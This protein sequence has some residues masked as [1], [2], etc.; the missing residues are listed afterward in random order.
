MIIKNR[1][2][3]QIYFDVNSLNIPI[4]KSFQF[5]T[6]FSLNNFQFLYSV[7]HLCVLLKQIYL[8]TNFDFYKKLWYWGYE[9]VSNIML[10]MELGSRF[11]EMKYEMMEIQ[12]QEMDESR[13]VLVWDRDL[14]VP[15]LHALGNWSCSF[16]N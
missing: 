6:N 1:D 2:L 8:F 15:F 5:L 13:S 10:I 4:V 7:R 11:Q 16:W 14:P 9:L 12:Y 3:K